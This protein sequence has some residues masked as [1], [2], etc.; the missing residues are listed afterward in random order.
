MIV[1]HPAPGYVLA[2]YSGQQDKT[3]GGILLPKGTLHSPIVTVVEDG[4]PPPTPGDEDWVPAATSLF[5]VEERGR[6]V[7]AGV[8]QM[9]EVGLDRLF[10]VP[11]RAIIAS[12]EEM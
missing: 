12:V 6:V 1:I 7:V 5:R 4:G 9:V 10:L 11:Y 2:R 8:E 3:P